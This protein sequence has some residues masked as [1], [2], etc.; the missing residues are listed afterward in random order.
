LLSHPEEAKQLAQR[1]RE[2]ILRRHTC[3]HRVNELLR[4]VQNLN[5]WARDETQVEIGQ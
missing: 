5:E 1:G 3:G 2:T 4:I